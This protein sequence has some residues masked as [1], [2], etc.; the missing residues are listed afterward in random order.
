VEGVHKEFQK[1]V[2]AGVCR[3][4]PER[5]VLSLISRY[6]TSQKHANMVQDMHFRNLNQKV[7]KK[8]HFPPQSPT[9][10]SPIFVQVMLLKR[11]E[12][13][14]RMLESTKLHNIGGFSDEFKVREDLMGLAIG[15]HG[16]NIQTARK[17]PG[18]TNIELEEQTCTFKIYGE[19]DDA[20]KKARSMLEY[21]E[22]SIQVPRNLVGKVIGK[23]GRII[24]EIVDKSGVVR[25]KVSS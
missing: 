17:L 12:E 3:Y 10:F 11:T 4:I 1:A 23:N 15:A 6:P 5:G 19:S 25:V 7:R 24:Q 2:N 14:A 13:A 18:V 20:V 22:E 21:S 16:A 8:M 9:T